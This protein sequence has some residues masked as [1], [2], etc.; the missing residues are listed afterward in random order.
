MATRLLFGGN[1][2]RQPAFEEVE[3]RVVG[4]LASSDVVMNQSLWIGCY[5]GLSE[6]MIAYIVE[7]FGSFLDGAEAGPLAWTSPRR[8]Y[9]SSPD[10]RLT[11]NRP[12]TA[13]S[14]MRGRS[15]WSSDRLPDRPGDR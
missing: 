9:R 7:K 3:Y 11:E 12:L 4:D 6:P 8:P 13:V 2:T 10:N 5:P 1:L 15:P 14:A